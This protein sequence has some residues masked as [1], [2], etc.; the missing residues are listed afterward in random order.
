MCGLNSILV[1][2]NAIPLK[3]PIAYVIPLKLQRFP[4]K[5]RECENNPFETPENPLETTTYKVLE[6]VL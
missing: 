1:I 5:L 2:V 4:L 3:L 6:G